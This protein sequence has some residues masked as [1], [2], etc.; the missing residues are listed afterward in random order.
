MIEKIPLD[1]IKLL[2]S[3]ELKINNKLKGNEKLK[4]LLLNL[5]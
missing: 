1:I 5:S 4:S 2:Y 3:V